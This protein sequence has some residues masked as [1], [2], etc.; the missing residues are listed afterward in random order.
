MHTACSMG[1]YMPSYFARTTARSKTV[2][3]PCGPDLLRMDGWRVPFSRSRFRTLRFFSRSCTTRQRRYPFCGRD[4]VRFGP[5]PDF[6]PP[7][8]KG[9]LLA[10]EFRNGL[11]LLPILHHPARE[12]IQQP[13]GL[14]RQSKVTDHVQELQTVTAKPRPNKN[15]TAS[16][17][18]RHASC[19]LS[20][21]MAGRVSPTRATPGHRW[22]WFRMKV[23]VTAPSILPPVCSRGLGV[24]GVATDVGYPTAPCFDS[25]RCHFQPIS[26]WTDSHWPGN[27][28][29]IKA[30]G[31]TY[32][33]APE[34]RLVL[35][36]SGC[37]G[38]RST[39]ELGTRVSAEK[40][41]AASPRAAVGH[42]Q[43]A[44]A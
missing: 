28:T 36:I 44:R 1:S 41:L 33:N 25:R 39:A 24:C 19:I 34:V 20:S 13:F 40:L 12:S 38:V 43:A 18:N 22:C 26:T 23:P 30:R 3:E 17:D 4:S 29:C 35:G 16:S 42:C 6:A 9:T 2:D 27:V 5:F 7:G 15:R 37:C 8:K 11:V 21:A 10:V 14:G 32:P 31:P